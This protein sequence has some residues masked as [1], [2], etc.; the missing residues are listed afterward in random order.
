MTRM[1]ITVVEPD[2]TLARSITRIAQ[3]YRVR[4]AS[5]VHAVVQAANSSQRPL[6]LDLIAHARDGKLHLGQW[7]ISASE[8][9]SEQLFQGLA[10]GTLA[11][12]RL[13]GCFT[14]H[15]VAGRRAMRHLKRGLTEQLGNSI[16]VYGTRNLIGARDFEQDGFRVDREPLLIEHDQLPAGDLEAIRDEAAWFSVL[17]SLDAPFP[18]ASQLQLES[19]DEARADAAT[20]KPVKWKVE[21]SRPGHG[22][23]DDVLANRDSEPWRDPGLLQLP[24]VELLFPVGSITGAARFVRVTSLFEGRYVRVYPIGWPEGILFRTRQPLAR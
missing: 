1:N 14:G 9:A 8:T 6:Q 2:R 16:R 4:D 12:V 22:S 10:P 21:E 13:L 17:E 23:I 5:D 7:E 20:Y 3:V 15:T 11:A 24:D 19:G 18:S